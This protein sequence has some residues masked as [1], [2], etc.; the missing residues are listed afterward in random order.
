LLSV[1]LAASVAATTT[2][3]WPVR[4]LAQPVAL[5][6]SD[7]RGRPFDLEELRGRVVAITFAS[8]Y[9][10]KEADEVNRALAGR[11]T[12]VVN[13]VDL[14]GV[15]SIFKGYAKRRAAEHD[16]EGRVVH[17]VDDGGEMRRRFQAD[18]TRRVDIVVV[19]PDGEV[20]GRFVGT[21]ELSRALALVDT[22]R[23]TMVTAG[24]RPKM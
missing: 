24:E 12:M 7:A 2:A 8:R 17:L 21:A 10:H 22:L 16:E 6:T 1:A 9:T 11:G 5:H 19:G 18:P 23:S 14:T 4:G 13:V 20:R 15:P 3:A